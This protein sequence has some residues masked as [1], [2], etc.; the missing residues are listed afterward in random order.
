MVVLQIV[1][2]V[3]VQVFTLSHTATSVDFQRRD[4]YK[5]PAIHASLGSTICC[6]YCLYIQDDCSASASYTEH[7]LGILKGDAEEGRN[8]GKFMHRHVF[9]VCN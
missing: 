4:L 8:V 3:P 5:I 6:L 1:D 2:S 7:S 9:C